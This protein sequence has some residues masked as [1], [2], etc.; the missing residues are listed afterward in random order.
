MEPHIYENFVVSWIL[1]QNPSL[2]CVLNI[3][4]G[5]AYYLCCYNACS[6]AHQ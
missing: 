2:V 5:L 1:I 3:G 6:Q 4:L